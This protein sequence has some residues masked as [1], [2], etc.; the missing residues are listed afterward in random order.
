[1]A[2]GDRRARIERGRRDAATGIAATGLPAEPGDRAHKD[3]GP[4][5]PGRSIELPFPA[6]PGRVSRGRPGVPR[7]AP[8]W[9]RT[10]PPA[11]GGGGAPPASPRSWRAVVPRPRGDYS[12]DSP[13]PSSPS[14]RLGMVNI[15]VRADRPPEGGK[16]RPQSGASPAPCDHHFE[17]RRVERMGEGAADHALFHPDDLGSARLDPRQ[18]QPD[19]V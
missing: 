14:H 13:I 18:A 16:N 2:P 6:P 10:G 8:P 3:A 1:M 17:H 15:S 11:R 5:T 12:N 19:I 9:P 7:A 4:G